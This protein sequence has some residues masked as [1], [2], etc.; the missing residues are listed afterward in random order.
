[1]GVEIE[2]KWL[3]DPDN[4][5]D[6]KGIEYYNMVQGYIT[7]EKNKCVRVRRAGP[8]G[9]LTIKGPTTGISRPEFE[10]KIHWEEAQKMLDTMC[11][12][13]ISKKRYMMEY[14][15]IFVKKDLLCSYLE[16]E[17]TIE[18]DIFNEDNEGLIIAEVEFKSEEEAK[19][20]VVPDWFGED[21]SEDPRYYNA[22]LAKKSYKQILK[23]E[24]WADYPC[25]GGCIHAQRTSYC[26]DCGPDNY[27]YER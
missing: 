14:G 16:K 13:I 7:N 10:Y 24:L 19:A 4:V 12:D 8:N 9:W 11:G 6:L 18:L 2:R 26:R 1:M 15:Y 21:V 22:S 27:K 17:Y 20:F 5:P 3:I 23:D 25:D